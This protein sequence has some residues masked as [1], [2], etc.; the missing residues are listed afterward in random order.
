[1]A[2]GRADVS[3]EELQHQLKQIV[4]RHLADRTLIKRDDIRKVQAELYNLYGE[5][6]NYITTIKNILIDYYSAML[7]K[8]IR[9]LDTFVMQG[10]FDSLGDDDGDAGEVQVQEE[11]VAARAA[12]A[13]QPSAYPAGLPLV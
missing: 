10:E 6:V 12:V 9:Q 7:L 5:R 2:E 13:E 3:E 1:M 4:E 11:T 8:E